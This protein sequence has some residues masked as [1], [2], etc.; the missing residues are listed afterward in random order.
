ML[1]EAFINEVCSRCEHRNRVM[2]GAPL[3]ARLAGEAL[4]RLGVQFCGVCGCSLVGMAKLGKG[5]PLGRSGA[6]RGLY[7]LLRGSRPSHQRS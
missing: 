5:C 4:G 6:N 2:Q 3:S 1:T 7:R